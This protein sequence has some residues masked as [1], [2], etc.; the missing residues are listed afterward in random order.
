MVLFGTIQ[1]S[2]Q[3]TMPAVCEAQSASTE[4]RGLKIRDF[5]P[6]KWAEPLC[7]LLSLIVFIVVI[8]LSLGHTMGCYFHADE[9]DMMYEISYVAQ[10]NFD[11]AIKLLQSYPSGGAKFFRPLF[12]IVLAIEYFLWG[13][14][15][16]AYRLV[17]LFGQLLSCTFFFL[18]LRL[19]VISRFAGVSRL[20]ASV[21][22]T[23]AAALYAA[24][25]FHSE[26]IVW[27]S[28]LGDGLGAPLYF[29]SLWTFLLVVERARSARLLIPSGRHLVLL[30][31]LSFVLSLSFKENAVMLPLVMTVWQLITGGALNAVR[32]YW[33]VLFV[34][35]V[36]RVLGLG[37]VFGGYNGSAGSSMVATVAERLYH[38]A[39]RFLFPV[40]S[41]LGAEASI[42]TLALQALYA[43]LAIFLFVRCR[44]FMWSPATAA[45]FGFSLCW[46]VLALLPT[47]QVLR[48]S[49]EMAG[50]RAL[51]IAAAPL[52]LM[53]T[54]AVFPLA[55]ADWRE[56][57][58]RA[59][60]NAVTA[61]GI[62]LGLCFVTCFTW[63]SFGNNLSWIQASDQMRALKHAIEKSA[64]TLPSGQKLVV[65]NLP[66]EFQGVPMLYAHTKLAN[67]MRPPISKTDLSGAVQS[68]ESNYLAEEFLNISQLRR[69]IKTRKYRFFQWNTG[70]KVLEPVLFNASSRHCTANAESCTVFSTDPPTPLRQETLQS[71][72]RLPPHFNPVDFDFI[73]LNFSRLDAGTCPVAGTVSWSPRV[74]VDGKLCLRPLPYAADTT[75]TNATALI[76]V[77]HLSGWLLLDVTK[78]VRIVVPARA[79]IRL[80]SV[81]F[82]QGARMIPVL[83]PDSE[84]LS[85][86][87]PGV[88]II[89]SDE[90]RLFFD[91]SKVDGA[92]QAM[93]E[94]SRSDF[95]FIH[96]QEPRE[97]EFAREHLALVP[98]SRMPGFYKF[99]PSLLPAAGRYELRLAAVDS[100]N[101][102]VG[103]LSDPVS[104]SSERSVVDGT[105]AESK[106]EDGR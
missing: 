39:I 86:T 104:I 73:K 35:T 90:G 12:P 16:W 64:S 53:L 14:T 100:A 45:L 65:L 33:I 22:A 25:P 70:T 95:R 94:I 50:N 85:E 46:L 74:P 97:R 61:T 18:W 62:F 31:I 91:A 40:H 87:E 34:Y 13:P 76:P 83:E 51:H 101:H 44:R 6:W 7:P 59:A 96:Y 58:N 72:I 77:S 67:L 28:N 42:Y 57:Y 24:L 32:P 38:D 43:G 47:L 19:A 23:I 102:V 8:A 88:W 30:S 36:V 48:L 29:L 66:R 81:A 5:R 98:L 20:R 69:M 56:R 60:D 49:A 84:T 26:A 63:I 15:P 4:R 1:E 10:G 41:M 27:S 93:L 9:L 99:P 79:N 105:A 106:A 3:T 17:G 21:F 89:R 71:E 55:N 78:P 37:T 92:A 103:Y 52:A 11:H 54:L 2:L 75:T 82:Q 80:D 68:L